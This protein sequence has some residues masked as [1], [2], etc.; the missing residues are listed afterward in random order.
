MNAG[1]RLN[2]DTERHLRAC[3]SCAKFYAER[4]ALR[5]LVG[6]L[7]RVDAPADFDFRLRARMA[8]ENVSQ[9]SPRRAAWRFA[10]GLVSVAIAA[11]F[12]L[13][14]VALRVYQTDA[15]VADTAQTAPLAGAQTPSHAPAGMRAA[16]TAAMTTDDSNDVATADEKD[17]NRQR[18]DTQA[19]QLARAFDA[20]G[21]ATGETANA[22][23]RRARASRTSDS[24]LKSTRAANT[25]GGAS[26]DFTASLRGATV[27]SRESAELLRAATAKGSLP[28]AVPVNASAEPLRVV[29]RDEDGASRVVAIKSVSFGAQNL[30]GQ[31]TRATNA[32]LP[33]REG[34]W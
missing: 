14:L 20:P 34:V 21:D 16:T 1:E 15:P 9:S 22:A 29:L 30:V 5:A 23:Q 2:A 18:R 26:S 17:S 31:R 27:V 6:G 11:L 28:V 25:R 19:P 32:N 24:S 3:E 33:V 8:A 13:T 4:D 12:A 7:E 10:P